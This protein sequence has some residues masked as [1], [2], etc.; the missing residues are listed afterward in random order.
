KAEV[1]VAA[2]R[3]RLGAVAVSAADNRAAAA[4]AAIVV[5]TVPFAAQAATL[6]DIKP[7]ID[8]KIVVDVT[9]PLQPPQVSRVHLPPEGS[10]A[11]AAQAALGPGAKLVSAFQNVSAQH[12]QDL[13]HAIDCDVLVC[14]DDAAARE[15]VIALAAAAGMK[16]WHAGVLANAV[17]A[18]SLTAVL[19]AINRRYKIAGAGLRIVGDPKT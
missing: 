15:T 16:A 5:V 18:E 10:A 1:A 12:L 3:A 9:V 8:G 2:I 17:A 19:I 11:A 7:V 4:A 13:D 14:G 6:A